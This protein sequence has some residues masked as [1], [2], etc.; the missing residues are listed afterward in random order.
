MIKIQE[1]YLKDGGSLFT[2]VDFLAIEYVCWSCSYYN[3]NNPFFLQ[4]RQLFGALGN[5]T[6]K[7][8]DP[9]TIQILREKTK[10]V[11]DDSDLV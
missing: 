1:Y 6:L 4:Y 9:R 3:S 5:N 8:A 11:K 2:L 7:G 10:P